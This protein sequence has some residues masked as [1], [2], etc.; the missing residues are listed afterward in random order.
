MQVNGREGFIITTSRKM[1]SQYRKKCKVEKIPYV[2]AI[3]SGSHYEVTYD[4]WPAPYDLTKE[5]VQK[6]LKLFEQE[7]KSRKKDHDSYIINSFSSSMVCRLCTDLNTSD[8][9]FAPVQTSFPVA[10]IRITVFGS[11][12]LCISPGN[13]SGSYMLRGRLL[14]TCSR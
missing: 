9:F 11:S 1:A 13:C 10:K 3:K 6:I 8:S 14:A 2:V 12:I 5:G 4:M 7:W